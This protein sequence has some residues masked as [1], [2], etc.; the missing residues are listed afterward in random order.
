MRARAFTE[1]QRTFELNRFRLVVTELD[2]AFTFC[3]I[4]ETTTTEARREDNMEKARLA[5][6]T[7]MH[8]LSGATFTALMNQR[9]DERLKGLLPL[10]TKS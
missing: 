5:Y 6:R 9:I 2:L 1:V 3:R 7:A 8:F 4:A 10:L